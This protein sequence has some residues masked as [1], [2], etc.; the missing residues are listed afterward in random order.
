M[1]PPLLFINICIMDTKIKTLIKKLF[2]NKKL[3]VLV[4]ITASSYQLSDVPVIARIG[5]GI[6]S[7]W[8]FLVFILA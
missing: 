1:L 7:A 4:M 6:A 8:A 5:M 3:A 2:V